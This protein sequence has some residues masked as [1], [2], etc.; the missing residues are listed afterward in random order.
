MF[1]APRVLEEAESQ[2]HA[3]QGTET[4]GIMIGSLWQDT[5]AGEIFVEITAQIP[6]E[7]TA[8][9]NTKLTFTANTGPRR[10]PPCACAGAAKCSSDIG[11]APR[12]RMVQEQEARFRAPPFPLRGG[13]LAARLRAAVPPFRLG[14][15]TAPAAVDQAGAGGPAP[16]FVLLRRKGGRVCRPGLGNAGADA[17]QNAA[18]DRDGF[19]C[20]VV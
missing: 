11:F 1:I 5:Q 9:S 2:T 15:G 10:M 6:A 18:D 4:G 19:V 8:S 7:H 20:A 12:S 17:K 13:R 14:G 16:A 3:F